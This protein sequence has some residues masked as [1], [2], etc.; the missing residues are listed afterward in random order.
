MFTHSDKQSGTG[1]RFYKI[2]ELNLFGINLIGCCMNEQHGTTCI[3]KCQQMFSCLQ[4]FVQ[5]TACENKIICC[6][7]MY[8]F[9]FK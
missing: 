7:I 1:R 5:M 6:R 9:N 3:A 4:Y 2:C 8:Y